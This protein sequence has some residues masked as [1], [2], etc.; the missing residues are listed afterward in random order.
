MTSI[1]RLKMC[2]YVCVYRKYR[3]LYVQDCSYTYMV[4]AHWRISHRENYSSGSSREKKP[5]DHL[6]VCVYRTTATTAAT[7]VSLNSTQS[8]YIYSK[9]TLDGL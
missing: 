4:E 1:F 9:S 7:E 8:P 2:M 3:D 5:I 6:Y